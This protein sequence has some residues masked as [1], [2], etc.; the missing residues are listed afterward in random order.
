MDNEGRSCVYG[1][2]HQ[3]RCL[4][5]VTA[6]TE[7]NKFLVGSQTLKR[8]NEIH[9]IDFHEDEF[10]ITS[11]IYQHSEE[12]WDIA[13]CPA[14]IDSTSSHT[15]AKLWRMN[16]SDVISE[17]FEKRS[18]PP[19]SAS[20]LPLE[21]IFEVKEDDTIKKVLW[22][23][24]K[25]L[26]KFVSIHDS[27]LRIWEFDEQMTSAKTS[28]SVDFSSANESLPPLATGVWNPHQPEVAIGK[29]CS[30]QGLD[31]RSQSQ[32]FNINGAHSV[33]VRA[34]DYNPN[35]PYQIA[36]AGDDCKIRFWD[37]RNTTNSL[38][39]IS[40]HTHWVWAIAYNR[41]HDQLFL[42]SSSDCQVNLQ[43]IVSISSGAKPT[44]GLVRSY[45]Q[46][47]DSVY[48]VAWS[49]CDP[50]TAISA[51]IRKKLQGYVGFANL[52]NQ[53]HRKSVKKGFH[54]T[55]MIVGESGLGKSTLVNTLFGT[56]LY[57]NKGETEPSDE[58]PKTVEIQSL[59]ADI[60]E[61][62]V[63][64]RL[65]VVDTPGFGDFVNNEE[66]WKPILENIEAR[67]DAYLEQE[68]RVNRRKMVDNRVHACIYFIAPTGHSLKPLDVE[69]MR[70]LHT[71]VNLIPVIAKSDTLTEDEIKQFKQRILDDIAYH[72]IQIYQAPQYEYDD[73][74]TLAEN[75]EII[76]K[77]PFAIVGSDKEVELP[78]GRRVRGRK[79]PWGVIEV[80]NEEHN[81][82]VKLRQM[83]IRTHMEELKEHTNDV[84][85]ENYRSEKLVTMGVQQD[86]TVFKEVNPLAKMEEERALHEAKLQKMETEMKMVFQQKVQEKEAKLKQ[87]EE[88]LYAR[89][90]EMKD[91]LEKQRLELE[92]KKRRLESGRPITPEKAKKKGFS[93]N[94]K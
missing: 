72:K 40:D 43:S 17:E 70:R 23:P 67:F 39:Q 65:T 84:L 36:S 59:S 16:N 35:K 57:P 68:N 2:R 93:F 46:H 26:T 8:D 20:H 78:D 54:F 85:Y 88:E 51:V 45:D 42:S 21:C 5:A 81:D 25:D 79:Y 27:S 58:T 30:V 6:E 11:T 76:S 74:E 69:F 33:L 10:E 13:A 15:K 52:P 71:K 61:N 66:S 1:L 3:A 60:E 94:N 18:R 32:T 31:L 34:L 47:E 77:I 7:Q 86:Q 55:V 4:T 64:L 75:R 53:V 63:K 73:Q 44:D 50:W 49:T 19:R 87:S 38:K 14:K 91:A 62:G 37:L 41:F 83:L 48:A 29:E 24:K 80:D 22:D 82:F 56:T 89:H 9:L 28:H 12:V 90:K 92:E